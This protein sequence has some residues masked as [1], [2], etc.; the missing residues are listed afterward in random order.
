M[1]DTWLSPF[2]ELWQWLL[3]EQP[4]VLGG[5]A[6]L[7]AA[8][9]GFLIVGSVRNRQLWWAVHKQH[10]LIRKLAWQ[11]YLQQMTLVGH[12]DLEE[13]LL[14]CHEHDI[15]DESPQSIELLQAVYYDA[16]DIIGS[17]L[18]SDDARVII[19]Q[20]ALHKAEIDALA[21]RPASH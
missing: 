10:Q 13:L 5:F 1:I 19:E 20:Y 9:L 17:H 12:I 11:M 14:F 4:F 16:T 7:L 8:G 6:A 3:R 15:T 18:S 21:F 2:A